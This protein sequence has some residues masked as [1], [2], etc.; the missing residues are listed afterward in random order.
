[1]A[2]DAWEIQTPYENRTLQQIVAMVTGLVD[3]QT[4]N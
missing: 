2:A 1:M 4:V 3:M